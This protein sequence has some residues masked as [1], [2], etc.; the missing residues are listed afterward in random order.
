[1]SVGVLGGTFDPIHI[2]HLF[3]AEE[4]Y[5][6]LRL[7][8]VYFAPAREPPHKAGEP[9][10]SIEHRVAMVRAAIASNDHFALSLVDVNRPG[11][12]YS[13][14]TLR[15]LRKEWGTDVQ[16]FFIMG[17]DS[18]LDLPQWHQPQELIRLCELAVVGRPGYY[19]DINALEETVPGLREKIHFVSSPT[20]NISS[21]DIQRRVRAAHPIRY[22]VPETVREYIY[23]HGLYGET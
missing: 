21:S 6:A 13:V 20:L 14:D 17:L 9:V 12:S 23:Q 8:K 1:M 22:L 5:A 2:G 16:L 15:L 11:P 10:T 18:L 4:V 19:P 3:I 7:A